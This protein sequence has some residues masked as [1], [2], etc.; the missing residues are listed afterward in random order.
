MTID[1]GTLFKNNESTF[2][3]TNYERSG[4]GAICAEGA[5]VYIYDAVF[6]GNTATSNGGAIAHD[7]G[8]LV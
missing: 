1:G 3:N 8:E 6:D 7:G 2:T 5:S 4:G